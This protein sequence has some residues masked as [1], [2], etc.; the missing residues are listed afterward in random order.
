MQSN[1]T[2]K[3]IP[4]ASIRYN[5]QNNRSMEPED[6]AVLAGTIARRG[7]LQ[8]PV[9]YEE[10]GEY[11]LL[12]GHR[13]IAALRQIQDM[14]N[15]GDAL[16]E[17]SPLTLPLTD[18]EAIVVP[19]PK[20]KFEEQQLLTEGNI[21]RWRPEELQN[22]IQ[23]SRADWNAFS[24]EEREQC[25]AVLR[26]QFVRI[27]KGTPAYEKDPEKFM[28]DNFR[29]ADEYI[30][31]TTGQ[32]LSKNTIRKVEQGVSAEDNDPTKDSAENKS[33]M[34]TEALMKKVYKQAKSLIGIIAL[35][36]TDDPIIN[37]QLDTCASDLE[38]LIAFI[39]D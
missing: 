16:P 37:G 11:V 34:S 9:V 30:R 6:I 38:T 28:R 8:P 14:L 26:K 25:K 35:L 5:P 15:D 17:K 18:V 39:E 1:T 31:F 27:H 21:H 36:D 7:L 33:Q 24:E 29:P 10:N 3:K 4:I 19:K 22:E 12:G 13:R 2:T 32:N 23:L 20:N